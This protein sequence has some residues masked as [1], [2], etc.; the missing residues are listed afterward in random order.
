[1]NG[2]GRDDSTRKPTRTEPLVK[3]DIMSNLPSE[4]KEGNDRFG[5]M[6]QF[7]VF[8]KAHR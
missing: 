3:F 7:V 8:A 2:P 4:C 6:R 5:E 1:M